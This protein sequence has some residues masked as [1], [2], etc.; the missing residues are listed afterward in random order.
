MVV[1]ERDGLAGPDFPRVDLAGFS[2]VARVLDQ[3]P[4][5][6]EKKPRQVS[7]ADLGRL[8]GGRD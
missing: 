2:G 8:P 5:A 4:V 3:A 7:E 1:D 6:L